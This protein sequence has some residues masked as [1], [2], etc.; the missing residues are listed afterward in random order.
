MKINKM[1]LTMDTE[2]TGHFYFTN[3]YVLMAGTFYIDSPYVTCST[4][5][6]TY[7]GKESQI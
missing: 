3:E 1:H 5:D 7:L 4:R 2:L 6:P